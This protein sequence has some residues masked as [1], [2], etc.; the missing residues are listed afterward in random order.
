[1]MTEIPATYTVEPPKKGH[2]GNTSG[3]SVLSSEVCCWYLI[4][5]SEEVDELQDNSVATVGTYI[6]YEHPSDCGCANYTEVY[7]YNYCQ[8]L[9]PSLQP[10]VTLLVLHHILLC[11]AALLKKCNYNYVLILLILYSLL[12]LRA[13]GVASISN[14]S[15]WQYKW[16]NN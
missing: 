6:D 11:C 1:M 4:Q 9:S 15:P 16:C 12:T 5:S 10:F 3:T 13:T 14:L 7:E 8:Q 2:F